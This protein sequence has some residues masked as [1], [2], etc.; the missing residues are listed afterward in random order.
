MPDSERD[1]VVR[2]LA[3]QWGRL[4]L[5][6]LKFLRLALADS[7][8]GMKLASRAITAVKALKRVRVRRQGRVTVNE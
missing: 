3:R 1:A 5:A 6:E 7:Q 8:H 4:S 2:V